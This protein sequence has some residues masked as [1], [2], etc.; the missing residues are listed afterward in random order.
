MGTFWISIFDLQVVSEK[1]KKKKGYIYISGVH[2]IIRLIPT[3]PYIHQH[4]LENKRIG[5]KVCLNVISWINK[6]FQYK[7][8]SV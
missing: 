7:L 2:H 8:Y 4:E 6:H 3:P 1:K 5:T